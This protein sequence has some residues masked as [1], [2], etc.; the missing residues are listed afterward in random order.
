MKKLSDALDENKAKRQE[1]LK[2]LNQSVDKEIAMKAFYDIAENSSA[3]DKVFNDLLGKYQETMADF[4][5]LI[6]LRND[7]FKELVNLM[8]DSEDLKKSSSKSNDRTNVNLL[9]HIIVL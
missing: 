8:N 7:I 4:D 1:L 5:S 6:K 9:K 3:K 2:K